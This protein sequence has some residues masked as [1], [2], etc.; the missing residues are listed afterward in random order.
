MSEDSALESV[1]HLLNPKLEWPKPFASV[2]EI[3]FGGISTD[4]EKSKSV[5]VS[6]KGRGHLY[7]S[8]TLQGSNNGITINQATIDGGPV[9]VQV[10]A[11]PI[12]L[13]VGSHQKATILIQTNGGMLNIPITYVVSVPILKMLSRSIFA[14]LLVAVVFGIFRYSYFFIDQT[15]LYS[16][17][18]WIFSFEDILKSAKNWNLMYLKYLPHAILL[19]AGIYW[20]VTYFRRMYAIRK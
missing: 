12:G 16:R 4:A 19:S 3:R 15:F 18:R 14:G 11:R 6:N 9:T 17:V 10:K 7:G 8:I 5:T 2:N 1:Q 13:P 20:A